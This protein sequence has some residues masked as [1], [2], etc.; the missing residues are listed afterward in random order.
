MDIELVADTDC[1]TGEGPLW[2]PA[3]RK[4]YWVDIPAGHL[5]RFDPATGRHEMVYEDRP[6]GGYTLQAD[7]SL[8]LFRDRGNVVAWRDGR[9]VRTVIEEVPELVTTRF[10]DV[11]AD[12][13][14]RVYCGSMSSK[15]MPG[16]LH[17]LD[18]DGTLAVLLENQGTPNGMGFSPDLRRMYYNDSG[19]ARTWVFDYDRAT[20]AL[21]E[22]RVF[23]DAAAHPEDPGKP[24]GLAVDAAGFVW[25]ARWDGWAVLRFSPDGSPSGRIDLPVKKCSSLCFAGDDLADMYVTTAGGK[26]RATDGAH[27]GALFRVRGHGAAGLPRFVSRIG[28]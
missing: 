22:P 6:I 12:P 9:V 10:N 24:D 18:R 13:E 15:T 8:L 28:L 17:R 3:E 11:C 20:G 27:A 23:R 14:G 16:R 4:V 7:G 1:G 5:F 19:R 26:L 2:H 25:T 21:P